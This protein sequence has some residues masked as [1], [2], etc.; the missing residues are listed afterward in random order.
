MLGVGPTTWVLEIKG[1]ERVG[2]EVEA[3]TLPPRKKASGKEGGRDPAKR[4]ASNAAFNQRRA[5]RPSNWQFTGAAY[6]APA[7][8]PVFQR[9]R[10]K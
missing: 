6:R 9:K 10:K 2:S 5:K 1:C 7:E 4:R 8:A 3:E